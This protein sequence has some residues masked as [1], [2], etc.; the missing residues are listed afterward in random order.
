VHNIG[1]SKYGDSSHLEMKIG[2][3]RNQCQKKGTEIEIRSDHGKIDPSRM[4]FML[5]FMISLK[6]LRMPLRVLDNTIGIR[7]VVTLATLQKG[8]DL[9]QLMN[10]MMF[11]GKPEFTVHNS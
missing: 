11:E 5:P 3:L 1:L 10:V 7:K 2:L 6:I 9:G 8:S 4:I